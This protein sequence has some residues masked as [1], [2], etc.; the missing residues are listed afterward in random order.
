MIQVDFDPRRLSGDDKA[1]WE[2]WQ[3]R[4]NAAIDAAIADMEA[5]RRHNFRSEIWSELKAWL[6]KHVFHGKCAYC[7]SEI[8]ATSFG[9][10]EHYRPKGKVTVKG[11]TIDDHP[12]YYWLAYHWKNLVP[13]CQRC[14][15]D[16]GK[17]TQFPVARQ[18]VR[19]H[20]KGRDDPD[21]LDHLEEPLLLN[22]YKDDP[23]RH[24]QFGLRGI[25]APRNGSI[26][27][28][29]TIAICQ[30]NRDD[31]RELRQRAQEDGWR[32]YVVA[33]LQADINASVSQFKRAIDAGSEP[34]SA[35]VMD[36]INLRMEEI[37]QSWTHDTSSPT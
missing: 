5:G 26:R 4:A 37:R 29:E 11:Q 12:G 28:Q 13:A 30:L 6:L 17:L 24:V 7:E 22:P 14:N 25:V 18:H 35:A 8:S 33:L 32:K 20:L 1:W 16:R 10:A 21:A 2:N 19:T 27:G 3:A 34:Y 31:L 15:S 9:D 23:R 36:F